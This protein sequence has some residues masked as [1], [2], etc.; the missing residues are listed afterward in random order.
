MKVDYVGL[1]G[2]IPAFPILEF[3][4]QNHIEAFNIAPNKVI[5][6]CWE[7]DYFKIR[8]WLTSHPISILGQVK[9]VY[10]R[11]WLNTPSFG[12]HLEQVSLLGAAL[13]VCESKAVFVKSR[14]DLLIMDPRSLSQ[15]IASLSLTSAGQDQMQSQIVLA[16]YVPSQPFFFCDQIF[17]GCVEHLYRALSSTPNFYDEQKLISTINDSSHY[18]TAPVTE[19]KIWSSI[20]LKDTIVKKQLAKLLPYYQNGKPEYR[21]NLEY[22]KTEDL[23][24][25]LVGVSL[26]KV[27]TEAIL[28][29]IDFALVTTQTLN[30]NT[31]NIKSR[32]HLQ[33]QFAGTTCFSTDFAFPPSAVTKDAIDEILC[34]SDSKA[35]IYGF[36]DEDYSRAYSMN[37]KASTLCSKSFGE[38][39]CS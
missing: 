38:T 30:D 35:L 7:G 13:E 18:P 20:F 33:D 6:S 27:Y 12:N 15:S 26:R 8:E 25:Y 9:L 22:L 39:A 11:P 3:I 1:T 29:P 5:I 10:T 21:E 2:R 28:L 4:I 19:Q 17:I 23:Y 31:F 34:L 24:W 32:S 16:S 37:L 36:I 14:S